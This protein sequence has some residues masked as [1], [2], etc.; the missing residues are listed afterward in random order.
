MDGGVVNILVDLF[1]RH[2]VNV[3]EV[4]L[5]HVADEVQLFVLVGQLVKLSLH[6]LVVL[7]H[8][9]FGGRHQVCLSFR[10]L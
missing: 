9:L 10:Q 4:R 2:G 8:G 6:A 5:Q 1:R 3:V 7:D